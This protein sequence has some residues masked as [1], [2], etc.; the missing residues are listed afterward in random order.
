MLVMLYNVYVQV[1]VEVFNEP[2]L[3]RAAREM[4]ATSE[5]ATPVQNEDHA[6]LVTRDIEGALSTIYGGSRVHDALA[7]A[8]QPIPGMRM[9]GNYV[10]ANW[11]RATQRGSRPLDASAWVMTAPTR[12]ISLVRDRH[13][14]HGGLPMPRCSPGSALLD[15]YVRAAG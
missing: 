6:D 13:L 2:A 15:V 7:G 11:V 10:Q 4:V 8:V 3:R 1:N 9:T 12:Y 14:W 5:G